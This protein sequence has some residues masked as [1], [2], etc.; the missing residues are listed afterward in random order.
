M[1]LLSTRLDQPQLAALHTFSSTK[2]HIKRNLH[3]AVNLLRIPEH[4]LK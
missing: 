1:H 3:L 4:V 2:I